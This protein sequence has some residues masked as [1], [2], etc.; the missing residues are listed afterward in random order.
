MRRASSLTLALAMAA[1]PLA[2]GE[3]P[4]QTEQA[5]SAEVA[6]PGTPGPDEE[7]QELDLNGDKKADAYKFFP[8]GSF[9]REGKL[10]E[11]LPNGQ[12][13]FML[14]KELD[15]NADGR[16]DLRNWYGKDGQLEKQSYDLDFDGRVD[17]V[18]YYE[19]GLVLRKEVF[20]AFGDKPDTFK[21]YE[22]GKLVRI[23]RDSDRDGRIDTWEYWEGEQ[24]DRIGEDTDG[25]GDVDHWTKPKKA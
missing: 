2:L 15:L 23:E 11:K 3:E 12:P 18:T 4:A 7:V 16:I 14:R 17:V 6:P 5:P 9:D 24:I 22:K 19:K 8:K 1:G 21:F 25:D 10:L 20:H 13:V